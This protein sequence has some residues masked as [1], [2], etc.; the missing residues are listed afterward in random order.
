MNHELGM[1]S[2]AALVTAHKDDGSH[3]SGEL[4]A[5]GVYRAC[6]ETH[7]VVDGEAGAYVAAV[8]GDKD[9]DGG[10]WVGGIEQTDLLAQVVGHCAV[11]VAHDGEFA[12][13]EHLVVNGGERD[14]AGR[15]A[16]R[17]RADDRGLGG[18]H[19][20]SFLNVVDL[21]GAMRACL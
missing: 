7:G 17:E 14:A 9:R 18:V 21:D 19:E 1:G 13:H 11:D 3:G 16:H 5:D 6:C 12:A 10:D 8:A 4:Q 15:F 2:H 20:D